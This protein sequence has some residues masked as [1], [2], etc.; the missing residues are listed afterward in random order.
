MQSINST[1]LVPHWKVYGFTQKSGTIAKNTCDLTERQMVTLNSLFA[2]FS[3]TKDD[4]SKKSWHQ[5]LM[6]RSRSC[7]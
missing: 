6:H 1:E 4:K 7:S 5:R 3:A 2:E